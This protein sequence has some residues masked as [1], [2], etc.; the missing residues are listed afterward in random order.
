[1][2]WRHEGW[3]CAE[4][5]NHVRATYRHGDG[6]GPSRLCRGDAGAR[7]ALGHCWQGDDKDKV[8]TVQ[9]STAGEFERMELALTKRIQKLMPATP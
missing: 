9:P 2:T 8:Q 3:G 1:M 4:L 6:I 7:D 5:P